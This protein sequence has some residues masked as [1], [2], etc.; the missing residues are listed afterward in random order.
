[1]LR[2]RAAFDGGKTHGAKRDRSLA[3]KA[4]M[5]EMTILQHVTDKAAANEPGA[6]VADVEQYASEV[7]RQIE[8]GLVNLRGNPWVPPPNIFLHATIINEGRRREGEPELGA[9][10]ALQLVLWPSIF[11][12][13]PVLLM[14][15]HKMTCPACQAPA[16]SWHWLPHRV[17]HGING[18][19]IYVTTEHFCYGC[20]PSPNKNGGAV[21]PSSTARLRKQRQ[22]QADAADASQLLP[23]HLAA[24]WKIFSTGRGGTL[25]EAAVVDLVRSMATRTSWSAIADALNELRATAWI[26]DVTTRFLHLCEYLN[27]RPDGV[28]RA[29]P[30]EYYASGDWVRSLYMRDAQ[31]RQAEVTRELVAERGDDVMIIDWTQDAAARCRSSLLLNI[32]DGGRRI[33][34][35]SF[36]KTCAPSEVRPVVRALADRGVR[37]QIVYVDNECCGAWLP[38]LRD[39]WPNVCV[40]LD[41]M[42]AIMRMT[43]T[44]T[45]KHHP[46]YGKFCAE[47]ADAIYTYDQQTLAKLTRARMRAGHG[48]CLPAHVKSKFVPRVITNAALI[49]ASIEAVVDAYGGAHEVAGPLLTLETREAWARLRAHVDA[50]CL[51]DPNGLALNVAG[52]F[53]TIGGEQFH[54]VQTLRGASALEGFHTHQKQWLGPLARHATDAG[55]ALLADGTLRWN[56]KRRRDTSTSGSTPPVFAHG[57]LR[58]ADDLHRRLTGHRLYPALALN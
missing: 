5:K 13:A 32:M 44:T 33:L 47:L 51:C 36:M 17:L 30:N 16:S 24:M 35:S 37:P 12:W 46:W 41:G 15:G 28:P 53:T 22:F 58:A 55:S 19:H 57:A 49:V 18:H 3:P 42:H 7:K 14:P 27:I 31:N 10:E 34:F 9:K 20:T 48:K 26:R 39:V 38:I 21:C 50:G 54:T 6:E 2:I 40:R 8:S 25:C 56:R 23:A 11:V 4:V 1:M 29:L 52:D 45:S 43:R